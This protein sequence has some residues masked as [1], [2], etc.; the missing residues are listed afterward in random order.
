M[1]K[2]TEQ[3]KKTRFMKSHEQYY[4][5]VNKLDKELAELD[6][7]MGEAKT[8]EEKQSIRT[9]M[10]EVQAQLIQAKRNLEALGQ[11][12][13]KDQVMKPGASVHTAKW[14]SCV[15][16]VKASGKDVDP[17]AVCTAQ[18]GEGSFKSFKEYWEEKAVDTSFAGPTPKSGLA[19]QDLEG[20]TK[21]TSTK[22][23]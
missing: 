22:Q 18:L 17:Y 15:Q 8:G 23:Y 19:D 5:E 6:I 20:E 9:E 2:F 10:N 14:D 13:S 21:D 16:Q 12:V 7:K 11:A 4:N 1:S 3:W